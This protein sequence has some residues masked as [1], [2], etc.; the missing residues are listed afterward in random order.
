MW[1]WGAGL[2]AYL[3]AL[4]VLYGEFPSRGDFLAVVL[5][6]LVAA[7]IC[8]FLV[9]MPVL[10]LVRRLLNGRRWWPVYP[11]VAVA[12]GLVPVALIARFWGGS[13]RSLLTPEA[14]L[15]AILFIVVGLVVGFGFARMEPFER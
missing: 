7:A 15:F 2:G 13:F 3:V 6:S 12:L 10:T 9:Y 1:A 14:G 11:V 8:Y 5:T 4:G